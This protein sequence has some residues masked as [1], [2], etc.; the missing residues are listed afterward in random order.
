MRYCFDLDGTLVSDEGGKY[1]NCK[2]LEK[3]VARVR[4]LYAAGHVIIIIT[5]TTAARGHCCPDLVVSMI[6]IGNVGGLEPPR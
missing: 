2:P 4:E 1:E 6:R 3:V 5:A